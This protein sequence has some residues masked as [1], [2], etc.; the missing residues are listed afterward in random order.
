MI[1]NAKSWAI[2]R[3]ALA[4]FVTISKVNG[5]ATVVMASTKNNNELDINDRIQPSTKVG[6][7]G[8]GAVAFGTSCILHQNGHDAM[9]WS[10]SGAGTSELMEDATITSTGAIELTFRPRIAT[11]PEILVKENDIVMLCLPANG[12]MEVM[13]AILPYIREDQAIIISSHSSLGA[14]YLREQLLE[15]RGI[16]SVPIVAWGTTV[17]TAR[18]ATSGKSVEVCTIRKLV[19]VCVVPEQHTSIG[20]EL[21]HALFGTDRFQLRDGLL[22]ISLSNLNAQNHLGIVLGNMSR[23]ER[24]EKWSQGLNITP[25]VGRLLEALDQERLE[26]ASFL[27]LEVRTIYEHFSLSFHVPISSVSE[28]NQEMVSKGNDVNGPAKPDSRY[29]M[30]DVPFGLTLIVALGNIVGKPAVLHQAGIDIMSAMYGRDFSSENRLLNKLA[31]SSMSVEQ[32][33][34]AG[35]TGLLRLNEAEMKTIHSAH[36]AR[37]ASSVNVLPS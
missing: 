14:A 32:L 25:N 23:M 16:S 6:I 29:V 5:F 24:G 17:C 13:D 20:L 11:T 18:K 10:P 1:S 3:S 36:D 21:C 22:A 27:G 2:F 37:A 15:E 33:R 34:H 31:L 7:V 12:H 35:K 9:L 19:D 8:A 26:I 30:E 4:F 28:M